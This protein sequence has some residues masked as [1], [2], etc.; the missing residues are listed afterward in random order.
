LK[1]DFFIFINILPKKEEGYYVYS[2]RV[3]VRSLSLLR[4]RFK[5]PQTPRPHD[6]CMFSFMIAF[7]LCFTMGKALGPLF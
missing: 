3:D 4:S 2:L 5:N 1:L 6:L 7:A